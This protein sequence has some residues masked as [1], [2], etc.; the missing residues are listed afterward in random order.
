[1]RNQAS[2]VVW[3]HFVTPDDL[4]SSL[5]LIICGCWSLLDQIAIVPETLL[6]KDQ[7]WAACVNAASVCEYETGTVYHRA[8]GTRRRQHDEIALQTQ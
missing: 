8:I 7:N 4:T 6:A 1:M 3:G 5:L 2:T